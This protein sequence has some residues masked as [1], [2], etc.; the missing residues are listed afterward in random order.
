MKTAFPT[1]KA[2][3][4]GEVKTLLHRVVVVDGSTVYDH[5]FENPYDRARFA[6]KV[7]A[8][9][10]VT[11]FWKLIGG[12]VP[13]ENQEETLKQ[14]TAIGVDT[15]CIDNVWGWYAEKNKY[16]AVKKILPSAKKEQLVDW[17]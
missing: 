15:A 11:P 2:I 17:W 4:T 9:P 12:T 10:G 16:K 6:E 1:T 3:Q 5:V 13:L 14:L 8:E 7:E